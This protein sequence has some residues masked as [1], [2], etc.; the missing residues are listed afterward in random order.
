MSA[1]QSDRLAYHHCEAEVQRALDSALLDE[2]T[3][4]P[5]HNE[6]S[7]SQ[8]IVLMKKIEDTSPAFISNMATLQQAGPP[9]PGIPQVE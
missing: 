4:A 8:H 7:H 3:A 9:H 2:E 5:T 1:Q 6:G